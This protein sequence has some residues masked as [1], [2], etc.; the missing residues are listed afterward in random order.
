MVLD[1]RKN[2]LDL[3]E[4]IKPFD[5]QEKIS[6]Q[7]IK[8]LIALHENIFDR[9]CLSAH[10]TASALV[11][12][13]K[14]KMVLLHLHKKLKIWL[15]FGGHADGE[16]NLANV[17]LKESMEE[18]GLQDLKFFQNKKNPLDIDL[19][20]IPKIDNVIEH[21][22]LDFRY[23][24]LTQTEHIPIPNANESQ[25]LRFFS[26]QELE[27]LKNELDPALKRLAKKALKTLS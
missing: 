11:V 20:I 19:Q 25:E 27:N 10:L 6:I 23:L 1:K 2:V 5:E 3:L 17:A 24:L 14:N 13:P 8:K 15:Q 22:H 7:K 26:F 16:T 12:N 21:H 9:E 4:N 18:T